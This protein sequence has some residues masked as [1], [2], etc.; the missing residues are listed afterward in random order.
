MT[1]CDNRIF[2]SLFLQNETHPDKNLASFSYNVKPEY[3]HDGSSSKSDINDTIISD[4]TSD[5][6]YEVKISKLTTRLK[7]KNIQPKNESN[8]KNSDS[9][10]S[11]ADGAEFKCTDC[12]KV[13]TRERNLRRH[14]IVHSETRPYTCEFCQKGFNRYD[15]LRQH[16]VSCYLSTD[17]GKSRYGS[18]RT[19]Q[20]VE[21]LEQRI[22][23]Q[24]KQSFN[25]KI[26][27]EECNSYKQLIEHRKI[28]TSE[29]PYACSECD[30]G[31]KRP[32]D[33][34]I[35]MRIHTGERPFK[36]KFCD[37]GFK[38]ANDARCHERHHTGRSLR[39]FYFV[40]SVIR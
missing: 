26:C 27:G 2:I 33:L 39:D 18:K 11:D 4:D 20:L 31:F 7:T 10:G 1:P 25:C 3:K 8:D 37:K 35:H 23:K 6:E 28:H 19:A 16:I 40:W 13:F 36:C 14:A 34:S 22:Q 12:G 32:S 29:K 15:N 30:A 9:E 17:E 24:R 38:S 21:E 5:S